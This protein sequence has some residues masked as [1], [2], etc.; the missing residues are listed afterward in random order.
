MALGGVTTC[1]SFLQT[2]ESYVST[3]DQAIKDANDR[4]L[5]DVGFHAI[6][7]LPQH[8]DELPECLSRFGCLS[9][10]MYM[11]A[12]GREIYPGTRTVD[13]GYLF[14]AFGSIASLGHGAIAQVHAENWEIAQVLAEDL[15]A[16]GRTDA[17]AWSESRPDLCEEDCVRRAIYLAGLQKCPL[18]IVHCSIGETPQLIAGARAKGHTVVAETCPHYLML[19][20]EHPLAMVAKY[21]PAIKEREDN[22]GLWEGLRDGWVSTVGSD[23][24]PVRQ[25]HKQPPPKDVW[26]ARGGL[27]GSGTILPVLLSEGVAKGRLTIEQV[28]AVSS[29]NTAR[30]F[31]LPRKGSIAPGYDGDVVVVD[32]NRRVKATSEMLGLDLAMIDGWDMTGWPETTI[33]RGQIVADQGRIVS[34]AGT[35][36]YVRN[37]A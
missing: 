13:D 16:K 19:H 18:Y 25:A 35:G 23:H 30:A 9:Y 15:K 1:L 32:L 28:A 22:Q 27:P 12:S 36:R 14:R 3:L 37:A 33:V 5:I 11:S 2:Y 20:K 29:Y 4:A 6:L 8:L 31:G 24:I 17:A 34:S 26:S 10:K 7:M 21:N